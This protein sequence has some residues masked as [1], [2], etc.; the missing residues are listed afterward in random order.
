MTI[1]IPAYHRTYLS[2]DDIMETAIVSVERHRGLL[3][4]KDD[5]IRSLH[6]NGLA[7]LWLTKG[8]TKVVLVDRH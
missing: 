6:V 5:F 4:G 3:K 7:C 1:I 8:E 2:L